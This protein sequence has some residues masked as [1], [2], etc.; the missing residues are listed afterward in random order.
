ML[1]LAGC[2]KVTLE[3]IPTEGVILA[4][5]DSLTQGYGA[6]KHNSYPEVLARLTG[7]TVINAG[8]SGETTQQG[9][10]RIED[11]FDEYQPDLLILIE[12]GNDILRNK[13]LKNTK[14]NLAKMIELSQHRDIPVVLIA[15]PQKKLFSNSAPLYS[16]LAEKY[17]LVFDDSLIGSLQ[18]SPSLKSDYVHFNKAGYEKMAHSIYELLQ[19]NGALQ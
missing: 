5:G 1:I 18:R 3:P 9:L 2:S 17:K 19:D 4:F 14:A 8:V 10:E 11:E 12:G 13:S 15:V 7:L 6:D 16:E